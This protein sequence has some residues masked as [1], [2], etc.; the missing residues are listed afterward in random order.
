MYEVNLKNAN[1]LI[2]NIQLKLSKLNYTQGQ[3]DYVKFAASDND[4]EVITKSL[5][6]K[7]KSYDSCITDFE[8]LL[9]LQFHI[10]LKVSEQNKLSGI[11]ELL[12][13]LAKMKATRLGLI[14]AIN[15]VSPKYGMM[16]IESYIL[17][18]N[19]IA[20]NVLRFLNTRNELT[21]LSRLHIELSPVDKDRADALNQKLLLVDKRIAEIR[22]KTMVTNVSLTIQIDEKYNN[23][24]ERFALL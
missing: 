4:I 20:N 13:E 18:Q 3:S 6:K 14:H 7:A 21:D 5:N 1:I 23:V 15:T 22:D 19:E 10:K 16:T 9:D 2:N 24:I 17:T 12:N 11:D 8:D